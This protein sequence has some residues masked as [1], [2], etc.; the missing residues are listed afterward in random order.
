MLVRVQ[1]RR[2][3]WVAISF[4]VVAVLCFVLGDVLSHNRVQFV[5]DLPPVTD[6]VAAFWLFWEQHGTHSMLFWGLALVL[7]LTG[8][9]AL[10]VD[11]IAAKRAADARLLKPRGR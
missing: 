3:L 5:S 7:G 8:A 10:A 6:P 11:L 1:R 9:I 2:R 4:L